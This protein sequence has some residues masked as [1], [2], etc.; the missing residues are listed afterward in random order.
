[1]TNNINRPTGPIVNN[2]MAS[3]V[4]GDGKPKFEPQG[5]WDMGNFEFPGKLTP[6]SRC[7]T[8][9]SALPPETEASIAQLADDARRQLM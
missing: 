2:A 7:A 8:V 9:V 6:A 3:V 1:M 4:Q 5:P